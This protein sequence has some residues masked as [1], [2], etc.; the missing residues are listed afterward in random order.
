M[1][2]KISKARS[3]HLQPRLRVVVGNDIALGPGKAELLEEIQRTGSIL[4]AAKSMGLSYMRAWM[5]L[6]TMQRCF[7][8]PLI[9]VTRGGRQGGGTLL[10]PFG[11]KALR[12]YRDLQRQA[13]RAGGAEWR[14]LRA[15]LR[16]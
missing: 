4:L 3:P 14:G 16:R 13:L 7:R 6:K 5:M 8:Q 12:H 10:T 15:M 11:E 1:S 2:A 9:Q